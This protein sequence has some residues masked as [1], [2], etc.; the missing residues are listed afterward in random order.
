MPARH[1]LADR[2]TVSLEDLASVRLLQA[3]RTLPPYGRAERTPP[4]TPSGAPIEP[5]PAF[6]ALQEALSLIGAGQGAWVVG[7]QVTRYFARPHVVYVPFDDAPPLEWVPA[8]LAATPVAAV[9]AFN[10]VAQDT[11][12][13]LQLATI[14]ADVGG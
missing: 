12:A 8:W 6:D 2:D 10:K 9:H 14:S 7:A 1:P 3:A 4:L 5:G 13:L 11:A